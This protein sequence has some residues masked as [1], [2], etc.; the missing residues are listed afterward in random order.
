MPEEILNDA[1][2]RDD[3]SALSKG[4]THRLGFS[5]KKAILIC[6][7]FCSA[8]SAS[9]ASAIIMKIAAMIVDNPGAFRK[10]WQQR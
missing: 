6:L 1:D 8:S 4:K 10:V 7:I 2:R 5:R 3:R 9:E